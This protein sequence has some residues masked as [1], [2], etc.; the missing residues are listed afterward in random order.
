MTA[1]G[2]VRGEVRLDPHGED[3]NSMGLA[4]FMLID[5]VRS[6]ARIQ[7][8]AGETRRYCRQTALAFDEIMPGSVTAAA[9]PDCVSEKPWRFGSKTTR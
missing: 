2:K 9:I 1:S 7:E 8:P 3:Y 4:C 5:L 6:E